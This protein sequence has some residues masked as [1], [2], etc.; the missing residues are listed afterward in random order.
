[1]YD[2]LTARYTF[3]CP[4]REETRVRLSA[5]RAVERLPG[6]QRPAV[7]EVHFACPCGEEHPGLLTHGDLDW[8]P[9]GHVATAFY[10]LMTG[11]LE[12]AGAPMAEEAAWRIGRGRWPW[13]FFCFAEERPRPVFPSAFRVLFPESGRIVV[14]AV[15]PACSQVSVNLVSHDHLDVPFYSDVEIDVV[16]HTYEDEADTETLSAS[17]AGSASPRATRSIV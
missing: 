14:A 15:C 3:P 10:N 5:F 12:P 17:L 8:A 2:G 1:M 9:L 16:E 4:E 7:Y 13:T 6:S 11:R